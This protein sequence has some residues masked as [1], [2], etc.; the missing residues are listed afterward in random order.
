MP[1]KAVVFDM[2]DVLFRWT[3]QLKTSL[4]VATLRD[5]AFS[6]TWCDYE[7]GRLTTSQ[8]YQKLG[9]QYG[10]SED[11]LAS[12]F[13]QST[14][15]LIPDPRMTELLRELKGRGLAIYMMTN[16]PRRD[17]N[18]LRC[19]NYE[20]DLFDGIFASGYIGMRKPDHDFYQYVLREADVAPAEA[21]FLDDQHK[22]VAA[23]R[24]TGILGLLF[25]HARKDEICDELV[26]LLSRDPAA[27][28]CIV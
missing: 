21:I 6:E 28:S 16:I 26:D 24:E 5:M 27:E 23:A 22:N 19:T 12:T 2:G 13:Y 14:A 7:K 10:V 25:E 1:Y 3:P 9:E 17:F 18:Q 20:W 11:E 8:C 4:P 15:C